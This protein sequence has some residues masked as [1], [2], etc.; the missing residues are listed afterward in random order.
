MLI[1][2][3]KASTKKQSGAKKREGQ[4]HHFGKIWITKKIDVY[5]HDFAALVNS[6]GQLC[7]ASACAMKLNFAMGCKLMQAVGE[8]II[9][10]GIDDSFDDAAGVDMS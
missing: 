1:C 2:K 10:D 4:H 8:E 7:Q 3:V 6:E 9:K 5:K